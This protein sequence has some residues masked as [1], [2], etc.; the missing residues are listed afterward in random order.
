MSSLAL[1][2]TMPNLE[3][4]DLRLGKGGTSLLL[5]DAACQLLIG[6]DPACPHCEN[7][8]RRRRE[9][10]GTQQVPVT[11]VAVEHTSEVLAYRENL[12]ER[13]RLVWAESAFDALRIEAVPAA[14]LVRK[15][16]ILA[17][18]APYSGMEREE[19]LLAHCDGLGGA[20]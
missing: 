19:E 20:G 12:P 1:G 13:D 4:M 16:L 8:A 14:F 18:V 11:W 15:S 6:F 2:D 17:R 7:A 10:A 3:V 5:P 9:S